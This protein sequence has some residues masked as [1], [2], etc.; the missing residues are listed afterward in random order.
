M[1]QTNY[2]QIE[3]EYLL[4][5]GHTNQNISKILGVKIEMVN[6][7]AATVRSDNYGQIVED[8]E[9]FDMMNGF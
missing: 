1:K 4:D 3:I 5:R 7:I 2:G 8:A 6:D 9:Y